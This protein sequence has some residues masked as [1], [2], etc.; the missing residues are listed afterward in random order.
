MSTSLNSNTVQGNSATTS[1]SRQCPFATYVLIVVSM[2]SSL[3]S[4]CGASMEPGYCEAQHRYLADD[5]F[6]RIAIREEMNR[7]G[8]DGSDTSIQDFLR[9]NPGCCQVD[10]HVARSLFDRIVGFYVVDVEVNFP[11]KQTRQ[12]ELGAFYEGHVLIRACGEVDSL[13]GAGTDALKKI[14]EKHQR[15][16]SS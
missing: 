11:V 4:G 14:A 6:I 2:M 10:R 13:C 16:V 7:I 12:R 5:E 3:L 15:G 9:A 1:K 8:T